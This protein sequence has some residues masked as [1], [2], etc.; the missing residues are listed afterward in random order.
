MLIEETLD[1]LI[2]TVRETNA[3]LETIVDSLSGAE[4]LVSNN[5]AARLLGI[6]PPTVSAMVRQHRLHR[7]TIG[8]S[9]GIRL[10]EIRTMKNY[11]N[12]Q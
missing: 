5:E 12:P 11:K 3:K 7:V 2:Q 9:T 6:T 1:Q 4:I 10:S 8:Q